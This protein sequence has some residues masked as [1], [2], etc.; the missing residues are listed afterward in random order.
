MRVQ[1]HKGFRRTLNF[2]RLLFSLAPPY[3]VLLDGTFLAA[4]ERLKMEW[5]RLV[6]KALHVEAALAHFH[7]TQCTVAELVA[8]G[9]PAEAA[10]RAARSLPLLKCRASDKH[11]PAHGEGC[12]AAQCARLLVGAENAGKWVVATQDAALR[13]ALRALPGVPLMLISTNV[14]ILE[15][16]SAA[17]RAAGAAAEARKGELAPSEAAAV[18]RAQ[19]GAEGGGGGGGG[20][21]SGGGSARGAGGGG[22]AGAAASQRAAAPSKKRRKGPREANPLSQK[23]KKRQPLLA[24]ALARELGG[25]S[26]GG[27][28]GGGGGGEDAAA[29]AAAKGRRKRH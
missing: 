9:A 26:G 2:Y 11:G 19:R 22:A 16:P 18:R 24:A 25:G 20:G 1:R 3:R 7:V 14:L 5:R 17:S 15:P 29:A 13:D 27:G 21:G 23:K 6:P 10:L 8:L 28:G 12:S 4:G